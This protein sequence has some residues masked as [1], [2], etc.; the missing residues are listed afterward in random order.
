MTLFET[1]SNVLTTKS[2]ADESKRNALSGSGVLPGRRA[3][4]LTAIAALREVG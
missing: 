1:G 2:G 3:A 4:R